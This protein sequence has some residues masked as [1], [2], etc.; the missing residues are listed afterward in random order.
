MLFLVGKPVYYLEMVI[1]QFSSRS[2]IKAF[3]L[4]PMT[5]GMRMIKFNT[6]ELRVDSRSSLTNFYFTLSGIGVGQVLATTMATGYYA[7]LLAIIIRYFVASFYPVLPW[8]NCKTEWGATCIDS[9]SSVMNN[10]TSN[11]T[12]SA[13][14]Y[15]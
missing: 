6:R 14:L 10:R 4:C 8:S 5:R 2:S 12:S 11:G 15:F 1:G 13:E 9:A 3:D 7:S